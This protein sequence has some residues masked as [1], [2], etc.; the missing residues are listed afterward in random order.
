M[1]PKKQLVLDLRKKKFSRGQKTVRI[2]FLFATCGKHYNQ[3]LWNFTALNRTIGL[4][5]LSQGKKNPTSLANPAPITPD[6]GSELQCSV[7]VFT[8]P[9]GQKQ[10]GES[11][12]PERGR[13][14]RNSNKYRH[15]DSS[16]ILIAYELDKFLHCAAFLCS[17][18][19]SEIYRHAIW[20]FSER[21]RAGLA[22]KA[23]QKW[24]SYH[25]RLFFCKIQKK[26]G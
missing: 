23:A 18:G 21:Q 15:I 2:H 24:Y 8:I 13:R 10:Q 9:C 12:I 6:L 11:D 3:H 14:G 22:G 1:E 25:Y 5:S 17:L 20:Q 16:R 4:F 7:L 19:T 26:K